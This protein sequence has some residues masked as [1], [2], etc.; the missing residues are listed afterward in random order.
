MKASNQRYEQEPAAK[1]FAVVHSFDRLS[2]LDFKP[3]QHKGGNG[4]V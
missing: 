2:I 1:P 3:L 4:Y